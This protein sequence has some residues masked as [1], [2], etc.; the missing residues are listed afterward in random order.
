MELIQEFGT[1]DLAKVYVLR[2]RDGNDHLI[3]CVESLQPPRPRS[4]KWVLIVSTLFGCPIGCA[5]CDAG[6]WYRGRL[7]ADEVLDQIRFIVRKRFHSLSVPVKKFKVQ[8]ARMGEPALNTELIRVLEEL[9]SVLDA[10]GLLPSLSSVAPAGSEPF[11]EK[12]L[13][14]KE[15][16]YSNGRFQLQFSIHTTESEARQSLIPVKGLGFEW[17]GRFGERFKQ[18]D[19]QKI[20]LN[21]AAADDIPID[22]AELNP[23]FDPDLFLIKLTPLNPTLSAAGANL[24]SRIDP[25]SPETSSN[26]DLVQAFEDAGYSVILSIGE[27]EENLIGS[28]CGQYATCV[29][30]GTIKVREGYG[31]DRY[32]L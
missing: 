30:N 28:N 25:Y 5:M 15:N 2:M 6:G 23:Y 19:D 20:T 12:L 9:P 32:A 21:F 17:M 1:D 4:E 7:T 22:P 29:S 26:M 18:P 3:E 31:S 14:V 27:I 8:F 11:F 13:D 16:L 10:P 24:S